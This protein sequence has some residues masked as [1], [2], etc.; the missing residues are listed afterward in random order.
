MSVTSSQKPLKVTD[1]EVS[2]CYQG[3]HKEVQIS[4]TSFDET[5]VFCLLLPDMK[6]LLHQWDRVKPK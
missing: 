2:M 6:E 1:L 5:H 3:T 4:F